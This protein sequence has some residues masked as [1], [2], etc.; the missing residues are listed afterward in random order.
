MFLWQCFFALLSAFGITAITGPLVIPVLRRLKF[1]QN[2]RE[3]G[4]SWHGKKQ[5]TPTMGGVM[6]IA[7]IAAS[8]LIFGFRELLQ[9]D[10]AGYISLAVALI[11]GIIGFC[12]DYIKVAKKRNL[13]LT[14]LQK[15][16]LQALTSAAFIIY[17]QLK[18]QISTMVYLP[19]VG[20]SIDFGAV[21]Y[22]FAMFTMLAIVNS[23]NLT[24]GIDGLAAS[25]TTP[26]ALFFVFTANMRVG[27]V[28]Y[29]GAWGTGIF[30]AAVAGGCLGF[31]LY[32]FHPAKVFMGDTG[33]L[34]L[35]GAV[36]AMA[37]SLNMPVIVV[38]VG[39]IY[40][41]ETLS[42]ILQVGWF[43]LTKKRLFKMSP[44]HHHF[45][46]QGWSETRIVGVFT[47]VTVLMCVIAYFGI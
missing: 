27:E 35:G 9:G 38:I 1:G 42:V 36:T 18:Y 32:N 28:S 34:F 2:I 11:F 24:D 22:F 47:A 21:Y 19:F 44:I 7:G 33:S 5:G 13:G 30:A 6:F 40:L 16:I 17:L 14:A 41:V 10:T 3:E 43:K 39:A 15:I 12:D 45:E 4:P 25:V 31:L 8:T 26:V 23:V 46:M 29:P 37:F 20:R